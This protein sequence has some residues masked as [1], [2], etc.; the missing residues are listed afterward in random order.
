MIALVVEENKEK[1]I[2]PWYIFLKLN[3][4]YNISNV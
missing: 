3:L 1:E 2:R 4:C